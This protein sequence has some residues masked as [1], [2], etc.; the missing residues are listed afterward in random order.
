LIF[1]VFGHSQPTSISKNKNPYKMMFGL[2]WNVVNDNEEKLPNLIDVS[3][4]WNS[5]YYPSRFFIDKYLR[6]GWSWEGALAYNQYKPSKIINDSIGRSGMFVSGDFHMKY[7]YN[8]L[9]KRR[10][11][12]D[13]YYS[14]GVG[15]TYRSALLKPITPTFNASIGS[16]FWFSKRWGLQLQI[17]GKLALVSDI[18]V[19][20]YDY[21]QYSAGIVY[22]KLNTKKSNNFNKKKYGWTKEK[23]KFKR[24]NT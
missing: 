8:H 12:L 9:I 16:N 21:F 24:K 10:K 3:G 1:K 22:R 2:S 6:N 5:L 13:P 4:S 20:R 19:S 7:S 11:W 14:F 23:S 17:T 18:Y 15:V